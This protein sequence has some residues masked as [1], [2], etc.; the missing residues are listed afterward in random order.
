MVMAAR[1]EELDYFKPMHVYDYALLS[2]CVARTNKPPIGTRWI[3]T[4]KGDVEA[5]DLL[6]LVSCQGVQG[7]CEAG[8]VRSHAASRAY[9]IVD[10]EGGRA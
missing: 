6:I 4:N 1:K 5:P 8:L 7:R 2:E 9:A 10:V 3:D